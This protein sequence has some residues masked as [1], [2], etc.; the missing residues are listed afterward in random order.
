[1]IGIGWLTTSYTCNCSNVEFDA[2]STVPE[3]DI[4]PREGARQSS[5]F[6]SMSLLELLQ[7]GVLLRPRATIL[8]HYPLLV[9][10]DLA[11]STALPGLRVSKFLARPAAL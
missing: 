6:T 7:C 5:F 11:S 2:Y 10:K 4:H 9:T 8:L 1:M 3:S